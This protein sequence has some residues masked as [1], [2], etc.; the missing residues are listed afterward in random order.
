MYNT[1]VLEEPG[2]SAVNNYK[3]VNKIN[4]LPQTSN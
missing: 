4:Y 1:A 3:F 2:A